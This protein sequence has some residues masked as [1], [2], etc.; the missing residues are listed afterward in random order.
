[1]ESLRVGS[2]VRHNN[3]ICTVVSIGSNYVNLK[4]IGSNT[5]YAAPTSEVTVIMNEGESNFDHPLYD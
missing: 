4:P 1:M 2:R 5:V 3:L